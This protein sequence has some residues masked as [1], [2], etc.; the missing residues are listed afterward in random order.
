MYEKTLTWI[1]SLCLNWFK[2][3]KIVSDQIF[4]FKFFELSTSCPL[5]T[6]LDN[7][8][9]DT[10]LNSSSS[11]NNSSSLLSIDPDIK[12]F[13]AVDNLLSATTSQ[14]FENSS[15]FAFIK[16]GTDFPIWNLTG[17]N[18]SISYSV[19][20]S[21][22]VESSQPLSVDIS[23]FDHILSWATCP[24][25]GQLKLVPNELRVRRIKA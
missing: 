14:S 3:S 13:T 20:N 22:S 19:K 23:N 2:P 18:S 15:N 12:S 8:T 17:V 24:Q 4:F 16:F 7:N 21:S 25:G 11:L 6:A 9:S 10:G 1:E 5:P